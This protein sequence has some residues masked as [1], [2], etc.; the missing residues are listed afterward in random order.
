MTRTKQLLIDIAL[1]SALTLTAIPVIAAGPALS[2]EAGVGGTAGVRG[3]SPSD[4]TKSSG[5]ELKTE[6]GVRIEN[7]DM[8]TMPSTP[9]ASAGTSGELNTSVPTP[10]DPAKSP[11][12]FSSI[13]TNKDGKINV[14]EYLKQG[15]TRD[16]FRQSDKNGDNK[17]DSSELMAQ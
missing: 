12:D 16:S 1:S 17:L 13:D 2:A 15:G 14:V 3:A 5:A 7:T 9:S 6:G 11:I 10:A 8:Q 4:A